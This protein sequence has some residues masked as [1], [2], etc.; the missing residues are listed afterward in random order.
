M[1]LSVE[2]CQPVFYRSYA[3]HAKFPSFH[4]RLQTSSNPALTYLMFSKLFTSARTLLDRAPQSTG[5]ELGQSDTADKMVTTR[6]QSGK[7]TI[8]ETDE[9]D[10]TQLEPHSSSRKRQKSSARSGGSEQLDDEGTATPAAKKQ[11]VLPVRAKDDELPKRNTRVVVEIPVSQIGLEYSG[12]SNTSPKLP[13]REASTTEDVEEVEDIEDDVAVPSSRLEIPDS[14]SDDDNSE[15][16]ESVE[17]ADTPSPEKAQPKT[18]S[19][20][21]TSPKISGSPSAPKSKH[22]RFGSEEPEEEVEIYSTAIDLVESEDESSDDDAPEVV[23]AHEALD[24]AKLK[25]REAAKAVEE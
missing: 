6:R 22:K 3:D 21:T 20:N 1:E 25:E 19:L 12:K 18:T 16:G 11:K 4:S 13:Q 10:T 2:F 24:Q 7:H 5:S 8:D 9:E 23:G 15:L 14:E 17:K